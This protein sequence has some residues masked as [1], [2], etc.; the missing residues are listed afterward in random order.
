MNKI[1]NSAQERIFNKN[2]EELGVEIEGFI[3]RPSVSWMPEQ[4]GFR[5]TYPNGS[6]RVGMVDWGLDSYSVIL[7]KAREGALS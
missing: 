7:A 3:F 4:Y 6:T 2:L 5:L 1:T